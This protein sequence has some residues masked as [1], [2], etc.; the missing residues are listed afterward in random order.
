MKSIKLCGSMKNVSNVIHKLKESFGGD[1]K[2]VDV[3]DIISND[4]E[5]Q[6]EVLMLCKNDK[7]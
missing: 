7:N 5:L 3:F 2:V 6:S 1:A 4:I